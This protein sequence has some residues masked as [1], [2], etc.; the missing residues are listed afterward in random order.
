MKWNLQILNFIRIKWDERKDIVV[1]YFSWKE[2]GLEIVRFD[3]FDDKIQNDLPKYESMNDDANGW[4]N[5]MKHIYFHIRMCN[6]ISIMMYSLM[7]DGIN[8]MN[9][10][11]RCMNA[12]GS[13]YECVCV[14]CMVFFL[15]A[16]N[17]IKNKCFLFSFEMQPINKIS[18]LFIIIIINIYKS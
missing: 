13:L 14:V 15:K 3:D 1:N 16:N 9:Y 18:V 6:V 5:E 4:M 7:M 17:L 12:L 2:N 11:V 8:W 10:I